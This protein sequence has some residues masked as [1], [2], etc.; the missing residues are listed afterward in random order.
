[1]FFWG[2]KTA[3]FCAFHSAET[4]VTT[5]RSPI[6][7]HSRE[8]LAARKRAAGLS[9]DDADRFVRDAFVPSAADFRSLR[10]EI[11]ERRKIYEARYSD[12]RNKVFAHNEVADLGGANSL[13]EGT[14]VNETKALFAFLDA[15]DK[16]LWHLLHN[17]RKPTLEIRPFALPPAKTTAR[18]Q[19]RPGEKNLPR[20]ERCPAA[21]CM[22]AHI[23]EWKRLGPRREVD[24]VQEARQGGRA[25]HTRKATLTRPDGAQALTLR[26]RRASAAP[27]PP[28]LGALAERPRDRRERMSRSRASSS[29]TLRDR[30]ALLSPGRWSSQCRA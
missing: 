18:A 30:R 24:G 11:E 26:Q 3:A 15:L 20:G 29:F 16:A 10:K 28:P 4:L 22:G 6:L 23:N 27:R 2:S 19:L 21:N 5:M 7:S 8:A 13:L 9:A 12:V 25:R 1:M 17:G 14:T